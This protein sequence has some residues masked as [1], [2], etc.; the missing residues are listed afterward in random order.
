MKKIPKYI[1]NNEK[2][3]NCSKKRLPYVMKKEELIKI[4]VALDDI[5]I[6]MIIFIGIFQGLRIGELLKLKWTDI[7][8]KYGEMKILDAKNPKRYKSNYG[9]DRIVPINEMFL[10]ILKKWQAM[11]KQEDYV[12]PANLKRDKSGMK[13]LVKIYQGK[14]KKLLEKTKLLEID[15]YQKDGKPRYKYH[16]HTLR[17]VCGTN[18][19]RAGMDIF[20]IKEFLGHEDIETT[21]VY[22][23]LGKDDLRVA[24]H[25][26][27][28]FPKSQLPIPDQPEIEFKIDKE[29]LRL[30]KEI[31]EKKLELA[32]MQQTITVKQEVY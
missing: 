31:M 28:A 29:S 7:D 6:A 18:L 25:K 13:S 19:Y 20:Q 17:H 14:F 2:L 5:K 10:P 27:Y 12:I 22:C 24:S 4:L 9:K 16:M 3:G 11:N 30:Q 8:L 32:R 26:A 15:Y 23:E 1:Q 21:Q